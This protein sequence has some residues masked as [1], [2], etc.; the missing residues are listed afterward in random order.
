MFLAAGWAARSLYAVQHAPLGGFALRDF[1]DPYKLALD[2]E[3]ARV[4]DMGQVAL[5]ILGAMWAMLL[6][7]R[8]ENNIRF[9]DLPEIAMVLAAHVS[10]AASL[11]CSWQYE[12]KIREFLLWSAKDLSEHPT[13]I[14]AYVTL[15]PDFADPRIAVLPTIQLVLLVVAIVAAAAALIS[16]AQF[17]SNPVTSTTEF[18]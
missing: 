7:K 3:R 4:K 18:V 17:K 8:D 10:I 15:L 2:A 6:A 12:A 1:N 14:P 9:G 13:A 5:V 16:A 11:W